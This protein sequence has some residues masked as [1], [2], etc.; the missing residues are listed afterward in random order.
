MM[1]QAPSPFDVAKVREDFPILAKKIG[2]RP[3]IYLD[4]AATAQKPRAVID[5]ICRYYSEECGTV[6]R[7]AYALVAQTTERYAEVRKKVRSFINAPK[8]GE[9]VFTSGT[10]AALNLIALAAGKA[11]IQAG[12]EIVISE[13]EHH[14]NLIPWQLLCKE[15]GARLRVVPVDD[16]GDLVIDVYNKYL[17]EKTKIVSIAHMGNVTGTINPVKE[18]IASAHQVGAKVVLDGAQ[19]AAHLLVDVADLDVDFY[20]FSGHKLYGPTGVGV[21]YAKKKYLEEL[22]AV[23]GG[24]D[25]VEKVALTKSS[26]H[27]PPL[28]FEPGTPNIAGV[29]GLGAALD[30]IQSVGRDAIFKWEKTV[31]D[32]ATKALEKVKE[33]EMIGAPKEKGGIISFTIEGL[34]ALDLATMLSLKGVAIRT[35]DMCASPLLRRFE[36]SSLSR[37]SLGMY[38]TCEEI[39]AF[40]DA[41]K[42]A[43]LLLQ[44]TLSY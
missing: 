36:I 14:S 32:Y 28:K 5:A 29:I 12:D 15:K 41:L 39:D 43:A 44:P 25:M 22:P 21:L 23:F 6:N 8:E 33:I 7:A 42:G 16:R 37:L 19:A 24:S 31:L 27:S 9:V 10:T 4:S 18:L 38:T 13:M 20:T 35:G 17:S 30:Y 2:G 3:L 34:H 26:F 11:W 1:K 40:I